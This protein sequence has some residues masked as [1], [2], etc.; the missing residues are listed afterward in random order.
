MHFCIFELIASER[1]YCEVFLR[2]TKK[3]K[4]FRFT[5]HDAKAIGLFSIRRTAQS[6]FPKHISHSPNL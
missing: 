1:I 4:N 3:L 5:P 6:L 2:V